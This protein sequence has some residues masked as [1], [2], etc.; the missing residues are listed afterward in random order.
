MA[1]AAWSP[2]L[3][4][5]SCQCIR[6]PGPAAVPGRQGVAA[7]PVRPEVAVKVSPEFGPPGSARSIPRNLRAERSLFKGVGPGRLERA[8][9]PTLQGLP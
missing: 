1:R 4:A 5:T 8:G 3:S 7:K 2:A 6:A 9:R